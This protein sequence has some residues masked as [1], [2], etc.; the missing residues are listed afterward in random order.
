MSDSFE[1][2]PAELQLNSSCVVLIDPLA[3]DGLRDEL[4]QI[5]EAPVE[6]QRGLL[7]KL[8]SA[9]RI[10][11]HDVADFRPGLYRVARSDFEKT[12]DKDKPGVVEIDSGTVILA[13]LSCLARLAQVLTWERY[14]E[15]LQAPIGDNSRLEAIRAEVGGPFFVWISGDASTPFSGDGAFRLLPHAPQRRE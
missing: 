7:Q 10:G 3:L 9:L 5:G 2:E 14:D 11:L 12:E 1:D 8:W 4:M 6:Q 15:A 13:D